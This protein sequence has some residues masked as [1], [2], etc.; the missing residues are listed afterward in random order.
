MPGMDINLSVVKRRQDDLA[1]VVSELEQ[2]GFSSTDTV[3]NDKVHYL[4]NDSGISLRVVEGPM[5]TWVIPSGPVSG[6]M[7]GS[8]GGGFNMGQTNSSNEGDQQAIDMDNRTRG[9]SASTVHN[10]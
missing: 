4:E 5:A 10:V 6:K 9:S 7:F 8:G 1:Q 3:L 2:Q